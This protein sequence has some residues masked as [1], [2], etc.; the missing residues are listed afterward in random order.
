M[1]RKCKPEEAE[2][3]LAIINDAAKVYK[4]VIPADCYHEPYMDA[5]FLKKELFYGVQ[6]YGYEDND[7]L[8]GVI[9]L[10]QF[11]YLALVRHAYVLTSHQGKGIGGQ[12]LEYIKKVNEKALLVGTWR[13]TLRT[14][15]FY[16]KHGFKIVTDEEK[17]RLL[18]RYWIISDSHRN[19]SIVLGDK[20]WFDTEYP[21]K[22]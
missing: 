3:I 1:I 10:Q 5:E 6:F 11:N 4:G 15:E 22:K 21:E 20:K 7:E 13:D 19:N 16:Q 8:I 14:I 12:L 17:K 18:A 2:K 9:G